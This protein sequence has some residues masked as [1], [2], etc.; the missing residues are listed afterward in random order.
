MT[1]RDGSEGTDSTMYEVPGSRLR[2]LREKE[3][4]LE[5]LLA[6]RSLRNRM[7][8]T[9]AIKNAYY[10]GVIDSL[11]LI[12]PDPGGDASTIVV[13]AQRQGWFDGHAKRVLR[14]YQFSVDE[15]LRRAEI[16]EAGS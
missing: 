11:T 13:R 12:A 3:I 7:K 2:E 4:E 15:V 6:H 5:R 8:R 1:L 10:D 9:K 14:S 16:R